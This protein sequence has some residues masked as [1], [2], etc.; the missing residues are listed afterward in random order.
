M[1]AF[2]ST[3]RIQLVLLQPSQDHSGQ[4]LGYREQEGA[5][6]EAAAECGAGSPAG[7][8]TATRDEAPADA[9]GMTP[10]GNGVD[11]HSADAGQPEGQVDDVAEVCSRHCSPRLQPE[12]H[13]R[14]VLTYHLPHLAKSKV[15][16]SGQLLRSLVP[17]LHS[18]CTLACSLA[19]CPL[20]LATC[21]CVSD[22][23]TLRFCSHPIG[24]MGPSP[25]QG[26]APA[27][28]LSQ[29]RGQALHCRGLEP[30]TC[31]LVG[32]RMRQRRLQT[33]LATY[34]LRKQHQELMMVWVTPH[35]LPVPQHLPITRFAPMGK[36]ALYT[37]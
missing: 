23:P 17:L 18:V 6:A 33:G 16:T 37:T 27:Q 19:L 28:S 4:G 2:L 5:F 21:R 35:Y 7:P 20:G 1:H 14:C 30:V 36:P 31:V 34:H 8:S 15:C 3:A 29:M 9:P 10:P 12:R 24:R 22:R 13:A 11:T 25:R 26:H 32:C